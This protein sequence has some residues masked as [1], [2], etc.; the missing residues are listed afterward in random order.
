MSFHGGGRIF[1]ATARAIE[2]RE[3]GEIS[4]K[5]LVTVLVKA[6]KAEDWGIY[7]A[8]LSSFAS[9]SPVREAMRE[10]GVVQLCDADHASKPWWCEEEVGH[11][12]QTPHRDSGGFTWVELGE[13]ALEGE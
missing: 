11:Y 10:L 9:D 6:L 1:L 5:E 7:E 8:E 3:E 2:Q 4:V 13:L 12:P